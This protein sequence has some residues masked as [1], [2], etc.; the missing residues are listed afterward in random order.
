MRG[1]S[2]SGPLERLAIQVS[3]S[4]LKGEL[5]GW[6]GLALSLVV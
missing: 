6:G 3:H 4:F 2:R 1:K 5:C